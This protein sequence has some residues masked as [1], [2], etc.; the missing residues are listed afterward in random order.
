[1][2]DGEAWYRCGVEERWA[3][4]CVMLEQGRHEMGAGQIINGRDAWEVVS[5]YPPDRDLNLTLS[6]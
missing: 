2:D 4:V 6:C 5:I 3:L 1:M